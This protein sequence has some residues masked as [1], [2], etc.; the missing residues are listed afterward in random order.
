L[1]A[2][3]NPNTGALILCLYIVPL[4]KNTEME[5]RTLTKE[6]KFTQNF[7]RS[8]AKE[9]NLEETRKKRPTDQS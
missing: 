8:H 9:N 4:S 2:E 7:L 6:E 1:T 3:F 5:K